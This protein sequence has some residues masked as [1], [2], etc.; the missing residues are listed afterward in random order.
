MIDLLLPL[1]FEQFHF[2]FIYIFY[3]FRFRGV[4]IKSHEHT[5]HRAI[6]VYVWLEVVRHNRFRNMYRK[7]EGEFNVVRN[8]KTWEPSIRFDWLNLSH[9]LCQPL[10]FHTTSASAVTVVRRKKNKRT[11]KIDRNR[12]NSATTIPLEKSPKINE[13]RKK[14]V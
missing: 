4:K 11:C 14:T 13:R 8:W 3:Q 10:T 7:F 1:K 2:K 9:E 12:H 5:D 6:V